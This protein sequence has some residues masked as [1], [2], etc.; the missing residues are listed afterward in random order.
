MAPSF[1]RV[2]CAVLVVLLTGLRSPAQRISIPAHLPAGHPRLAQRPGGSHVDIPNQPLEWVNPSRSGRVIERINSQILRLASSAAKLFWITGDQRY[3][4]LAAPVFDIY[5]RGMTDRRVPIDLTHGHSQTL[6]GLST[7]EFIQ[8]GILLD[9]AATYDLLRPYLEQHNPNAIPIYTNA[10]RRWID[11]TLSNGVPCNNWDLIEARFLAAVALV[12]EDDAAYPNHRG[13]QFYLNAIL[14]ESVTRQWSLAKLALRGF[15]PRSAIWFESPGYSMNVVRDFI[16][17]INTLDAA[18]GTDLLMNLRFPCLPSSLVSTAKLGIASSSRSLNPRTQPTRQASG[19]SRAS[20]SPEP[21]RTSSGLTSLAPTP[22]ISR[23]SAFPQ[24]PR[25]RSL[26][27]S[28]RFRPRSPSSPI[29]GP[30]TPSSSARVGSWLMTAS[31]WSS[32]HQTP[33]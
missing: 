4:Q 23:S 14:N 25:L 5:L 30:P 26:S 31:V 7:F 8:E 18:L 9:L 24:C 1:R 6:Y 17:L 27:M 3:A 28:L 16:T 29:P 12:L 11:H 2:P 32:P 15:D 13:E 19:R 21:P 20:P 10:L 22:P 33:P